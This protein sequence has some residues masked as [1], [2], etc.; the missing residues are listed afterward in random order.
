MSGGVLSGQVALEHLEIL[1]IERFLVVIVTDQATR[2]DFVD[3]RI[4]LI[5]LPVLIERLVPPAVEPD[6]SDRAVVGQ[7]FGELVVHKI[8]IVA[9]LAMFGTA[10]VMAAASQRII[11]GTSPIHVGIV[12]IKRN[13]LFL[14][15][16]GQLFDD[17]AAERRRFH[18]IVIRILR[19]EHRETVVMTRRDCNVFCAGIF[20]GRHPGSGIEFRRIESGSEFRILFSVEFVQFERPFAVTEHTVDAPMDEDAEFVV[21]ELF[22]VA[23]VLL[24]RHILVLCG[25]LQRE[26]RQ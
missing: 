15:L 5:Q 26:G 24:R 22:T 23:Q 18:D 4:L 8:P 7:Q 20:N 6:R 1:A 11:V 25:S 12:E 14:T 3:H 21:L 9:P 13:S 19:I 2:L 10:R 16:V 17:V